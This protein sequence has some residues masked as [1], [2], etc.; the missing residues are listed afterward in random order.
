MVRAGVRPQAP[1]GLRVPGDGSR[2]TEVTI[3]VA[4]GSTYDITDGRFAWTGDLGPGGTMVQQAIPEQGRCWRVGV[5]PIRQ[6]TRHR[7]RRRQGPPRLSE[8][9]ALA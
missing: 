5:G 3:R 2:E 8:P 6:R 1:H 9:A 4:E 7:P